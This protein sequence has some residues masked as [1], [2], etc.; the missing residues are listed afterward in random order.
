MA[1]YEKVKL[2]NEHKIKLGQLKKLEDQIKL[3]QRN[4]LQ[5]KEEKRFK[6]RLKNAETDFNIFL[7]TNK[8]QEAMALI[9]SFLELNKENPKAITFYNNKKSIVLKNVEKSNLAE[10]SKLKQNTKLE[11]L[12]LI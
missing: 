3:K 9:T 1:D 5:L 8:N 11:A 7:K 2:N 12:K 6:M 10:E 4:V